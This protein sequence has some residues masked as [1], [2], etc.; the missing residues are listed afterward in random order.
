MSK[1]QTFQ[2]LAVTSLV[3]RLMEQKIIHAGNAEDFV[4]RHPVDSLHR[5][6]NH[7]G[8]QLFWLESGKRISARVLQER[9]ARAILD[10]AEKTILPDDE[11][12]AALQ[13]MALCKRLRGIT[14]HSDIGPLAPDVP[15]ATKLHYL[16]AKYGE[17]AWEHRLADAVAFDLQW[18]RIDSRSIGLKVYSK[19]DPW[20]QCVDTRKLIAQAPIN[21]RA[22]ARGA[23]IRSGDCDGAGWGYVSFPGSKRT[24]LDD[25]WSPKLPKPMSTSLVHVA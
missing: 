6:N 1:S 23:A 9:Y 22:A 21:S 11:Q 19:L 13:F 25:F 8:R 12:T 10:M 2:S 16:R 17:D 14:Q 3:L 7:F 20:I 24:D 18:H 15:W 5:I 4:L